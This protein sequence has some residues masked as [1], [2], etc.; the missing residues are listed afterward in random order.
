MREILKEVMH[1]DNQIELRRAG[2]QLLILLAAQFAGYFI[3][4]QFAIFVL[5][6]GK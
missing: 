4:Y 6:D 2:I 3:A 1:K 5:T